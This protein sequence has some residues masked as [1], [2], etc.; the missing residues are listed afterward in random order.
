MDREDAY[1]RAVVQ[2]DSR[3]DGKFFIGVKTTGIYCRPICPAQPARKN[4]LFFPTRFAAENDGFRPCKRCRPEEAPGPG[5]A[6]H[7]IVRQALAAI[8][9]GDYHEDNAAGFAAQFQLS[10]R[11]LRRI[12]TEELGQSPAQIAASQR[13]NASRKLLIETNLSVTTIAF[14]SGFNSI[15]R[16]ND[17]F[18]QRFHYTPSQLRSTAGKGRNSSQSKGSAKSRG[19]LLKLSYRPPFDFQDAL[20]FLRSHAFG[21]FQ[22]VT[23]D[24]YLRLMPTPGHDELTIVEVT[25]DAK[26]CQLLCRIYTPDSTQ[27]LTIARR[28]RHMFDLDA[29]PLH[30]AELFSGVPI[31][32]DLISRYPGL[33]ICRSYEPLECVL[34]TILGQLVTVEQA[35]SLSNQVVSVYGPKASYQGEG[36][37]AFP[38]LTA[39]AAA[40]FA[41]IG[42]TNARRTALKAVIAAIAAGDITLSPHQN[43]AD[44]KKSLLAIKGIGPWTA[45]YLALR[46]LGCT[47]GFPGTDL[48]I[49]RALER[50]PKLSAALPELRPWRSYAAIYLWR[51]YAKTLSG[52][53]PSKPKKNAKKP[54]KKSRKG[55]PSVL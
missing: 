30:L 29:D 28:V 9:Q 17:A 27:L 13:L 6:S 15:R 31:L 54:A 11:H 35:A 38:A 25:D 51:H 50:H 7:P 3:F 21:E 55:Q 4:M 12:F 5:H 22:R 1:Y 40:D 43:S 14:D 34:S 45:E 37:S 44:F 8:D 33:R 26:K 20:S 41:T 42:T 47:D 32:N 23:K 19:V 24:S 46:A 16:F 36:F 10:E 18:K 48:I 39:L 52:K 2:R 49:N 53:K